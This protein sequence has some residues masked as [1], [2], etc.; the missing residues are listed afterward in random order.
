MDRSTRDVVVVGNGIIGL[1]T[2]FELS[3]RAPDLRIAVIG[4]AAREGAASVAAGAMLNCFGEATVSTLGDPASVAKFG[5]RLA[6]GE[7]MSAPAVVVAAGS[8]TRRFIEQLPLGAVPLMLQ[9]TGLAVLTQRHD[10]A[11]GFDHVVRTPNQPGACGLQLVPLGDR[12]HE[13]IGGTNLPSFLHST[14]PSLGVSFNLLR[15]ACEDFDHRLG[16]SHIHR[17]LVGHRPVTLDGFPLLGAVPSCRGL[18]FA[19]GTYRDGFHSSPVIAPHIADVVLDRATAH[20]HFVPF[21]PERPPIERTSVAAAT[22]QFVEHQNDDA[23]LL[24]IRLPYCIGR[25]HSCA[26]TMSWAGHAHGGIGTHERHVTGRH[27][28]RDDLA[29]SRRRGASAAARRVVRRP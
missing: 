10:D 20:P 1:S 5:V 23:V 24:G 18:V 6:G 26:G 25:V 9:G 13:Y 12:G 29:R 28:G 27:Q 14:G 16:Y 17:W 2:A 19:S 21:A 3:Q 4:P 22:D 8:R 7:T 15:R 11:A